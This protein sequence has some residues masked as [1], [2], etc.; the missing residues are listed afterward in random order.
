MLK[1]LIAVSV[2]IL[3]AGAPAALAQDRIE[4]KE[5]LAVCNGLFLAINSLNDQINRMRG[6]L[7]GP[8]DIY[9]DDESSIRRG[10][11]REREH[12]EFNGMVNSFNLLNERFMARGCHN[13]YS[14]RMNREICQSLTLFTAADKRLMNCPDD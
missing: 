2:F 5:D 11:R 9:V 8:G 13:S 7:P 3:S 10:L 4:V 14:V 12:G 6:G 1:H